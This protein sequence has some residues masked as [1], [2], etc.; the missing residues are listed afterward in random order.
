M[1]HLNVGRKLSRTAS[2]RK[3]M[4]GNLAMSILDK[5]RVMTS[6]AKGK[7]VRRVVERL[8]TYGKKGGQ[9][10]LRLASRTVKNGRVL[11]KLFTDIAP[12]YKERAGGYVRVLH[13]GERRGDNSPRVLVELVGRGSAERM[14]KVS[15]D[16]AARK[17]RHEE[18]VAKAAER[19]KEET[20]EPQ[21]PEAATGAP[22]EENSKST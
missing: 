12:S 1:R 5:E 19:L 17:A 7:E 3:A 14:K 10:S 13:V 4:L 11:H 2:H 6:E 15:A 16:K 18:A 20:K 21:A 9:S 8:I 22:P